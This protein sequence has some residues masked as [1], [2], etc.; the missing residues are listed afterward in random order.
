MKFS[1]SKIK[2]FK[3]KR[4]EN[5][6][7]IILSIGT[8]ATFWFFNALNK[9][10]DT[11][12]SYPVS[13]EFDTETYIIIDE[14]PERIQINVKGMGWTLLRT[15]LGLRVKS[16]PIVLNNPASRKRISGA[17]LTN[18]VA[19]ELDDLA[20]NY[21]LDDSLSLNIDRRGAR[22]FGVYID[23]T[24][25]S[26]ADNYRIVS[27]IN[28]DVDLVELAGPLAM[29]N[30]VKSDSFIVSID[31]E[32]IDDNYSEEIDFEIKRP[33]LHE[34]RPQAVQISFEVAEFV[35]SSREVILTKI[36][37]PE[38][39]NA[40]IRDSVCTVQYWVRKDFEELIAADSFMIVANYA[41][42]NELD[43]TIMLGIE[44]SPPEAT[45]MR[46]AHPQVRLQ[47]ND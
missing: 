28:Y 36:D 37:F 20:L 22:S 5:L 38:N 35:E 25:I 6:R 8:A 2:K 1:L 18:R 43:S 12:L 27:S 42:V 3:L 24:N 33:D 40:Y 30:Q 15:T 29:I 31:K 4:P 10:Y 32:N 16:I 21:I 46:L 41:M 34:F 19:D 45:N 11:T 13:W 39:T 44:K 47:Y 7:I 23:S 26:L 17:S 14:L 9:E